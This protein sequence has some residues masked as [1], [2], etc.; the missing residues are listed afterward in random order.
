ME[1]LIV[2]LL[3]V[4]LLF[5]VWCLSGVFLGPVFSREMVTLY[6]VR[7]D[8]E[9]LEQRVRAY[10]WFREGKT[11]GSRLVLVDCGLTA[12][13]LEL[14]QRLRSHYDWLDTCPHQALTDY[15]E[16]MEDSI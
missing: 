15:L 5:A 3:L 12:F 2:F 4:V 8:G 10:G 16:L 14:A 1:L 13:G 7:G 11:R 9:A 6:Y